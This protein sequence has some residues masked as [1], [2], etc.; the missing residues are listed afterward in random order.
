MSTVNRLPTE[1]GYESYFRVHHCEVSTWHD[2][3]A[4]QPSEVHL[5]MEV[6]GAPG[7]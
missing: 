3:Y 4:P 5:R 7:S 2:G 1:V 6:T